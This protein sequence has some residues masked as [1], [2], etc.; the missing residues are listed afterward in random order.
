MNEG[1]YML[2]VVCLREKGF[3]EILIDEVECIVFNWFDYVLK[4][5]CGNIFERIKFLDFLLKLYLY[6][7]EIL[8]NLLFSLYVGLMRKLDRKVFDYLK[9]VDI[10]DLVKI[11]LKMEILED[12]YLEDMLKNYINELFKE[13]IKNGDL[14]K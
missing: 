9:G 10:V 8:L 12:E 7:G 6:V 4:Y 3:M 11:V 1:I 5:Y 2:V 14:S 13:G